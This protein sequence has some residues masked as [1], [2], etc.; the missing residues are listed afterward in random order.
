MEHKTLS[1]NDT[2]LKFSGDG[3]LSFAGYASVFD[4]VDKYGDTI[5]KGAYAG[6]IDEIGAGKTRMPKMFVNHKS[7]DLPIGKWTQIK[8]TDHGLLI[9]GEFTPESHQA[10]NVRAAMKHGTVDGLSIGYRVG[11]FELVGDK[12]TIK[13]IKDLPEVS[14]VTYPADDSARIDLSSVKSALDECES[15]KDFEDFLREAGGFSK[16][17][18]VASACR[19]KRI[20]SRSESAEELTHDLKQQI[21]RNLSDSITLSKGFDNGI[22]NRN[23]G[24]G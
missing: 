2:E 7:W 11:E 15:I 19:A 5:I 10:K 17:L 6:I 8:E 13:S 9:E 21:M 1:L 12:R 20:F 14:I 23:Q 3:A 4:G 22:R 24:T 18:A 16:S